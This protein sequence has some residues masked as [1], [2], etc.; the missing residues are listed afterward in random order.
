MPINN[1]PTWSNIIDKPTT[2]A[3]LGLSDFNS[4]AINAQAGVTAGAVGSY[5][6]LAYQTAEATLAPGTLKNGS[7]LR[8]VNAD[9]NIGAG[10]ALGGVWRLMGYVENVNGRVR[11]AVWLRIS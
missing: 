4:S 7:D 5:A 1:P 6:F 11:S 10:T 3:G 9:G 2:V 8:F